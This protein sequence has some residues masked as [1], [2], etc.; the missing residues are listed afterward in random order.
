MKGQFALGQSLDLNIW[1]SCHG[2]DF[3]ARPCRRL[4]TVDDQ[5]RLPRLLHQAEEAIA[6]CDP[7]QVSADK[8][9]RSM[10]CP[11]RARHGKFSRG[12]HQRASPGHCRRALALCL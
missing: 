9:Y 4:I 5:R 12:G 2:L 10:P 11:A 3:G 1:Q 8:P 7:I 6:V